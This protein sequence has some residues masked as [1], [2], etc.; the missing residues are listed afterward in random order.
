ME[1]ILFFMKVLTLNFSVTFIDN[2]DTYQ[3]Y[4]ILHGEECSL[5]LFRDVSNITLVLSNEDNITSYSV[6]VVGYL[7][8][9]VP[10]LL[11]NNEKISEINFDCQ[12]DSFMFIDPIFPEMLQSERK[13]NNQDVLIS[14][15]GAALF[16]FIVATGAVI[17]YKPNI[18][19]ESRV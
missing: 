12:Y 17:G 11:L 2:S 13:S 6:P 3:N 15:I 16:I 8:F 14:L 1:L 10:S 5:H 18:T 4:L 7:N 19:R 9:T